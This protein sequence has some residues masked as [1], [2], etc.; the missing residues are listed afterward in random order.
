MEP[1]ACLAPQDRSDIEQSQGLEPEVIR[2]EV[3]DPRVDQKNIFFHLKKEPFPDT[4]GNG[5][6]VIMVRKVGLEPTQP[7]R[8]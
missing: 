1:A 5:P 2:R 7:Y 4:A 3:I 8:P 6:N